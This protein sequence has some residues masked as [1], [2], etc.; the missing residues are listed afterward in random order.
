[1]SLLRRAFSFFWLFLATARNLIN[2]TVI[3]VQKR[4]HPK[5]EPSLLF[6]ANREIVE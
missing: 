1:L 5:G 4:A 2:E 3:I 6:V